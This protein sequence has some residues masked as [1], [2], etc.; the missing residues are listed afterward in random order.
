MYEITVFVTDSAAERL[1]KR[2]EDGE[3]IHTV[4]A[5]VVNGKRVE[6]KG[7]AFFG[8]MLLEALSDAR[9]NT[10]GISELHIV[11]DTEEE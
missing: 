1:W 3:P 8:E 5:N 2:G 11:N 7:L 6:M 4:K 9:L 10:Y